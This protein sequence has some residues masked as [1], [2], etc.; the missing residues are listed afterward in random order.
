[1]VPSE[2]VDGQVTYT[3]L[4]KVHDLSPVNLARVLLGA[5]AQP[6]RRSTVGGT[7]SRGCWASTA[8]GLR[9]L[10]STLRY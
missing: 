6:S 7:T 8:G 2:V 3:P 4:D 1:M 5:A 10:S 9:V